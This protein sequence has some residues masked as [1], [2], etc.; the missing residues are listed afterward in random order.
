M[1]NINSVKI[2]DEIINTKKYNGINRELVEKIVSDLSAKYNEKQ[3]EKEVRNKLHQIWGTYFASMPDYNKLSKKVTD[4]QIDVEN[5]LRIH[6]SSGER[7]KFVKEMYAGIFEVTGQADSIIDFG[8]GFNPLSFQYM[9]IAK[10]GQYIVVDIDAKELEFLENAINQLKLVNDKKIDFKFVCQSALEFNYT[11]YEKVDIIFMLKLL[12]N[13]EQQDKGKGIEFFLNSFDHAKYVVVSFPTKS[14]SGNQRI[15]RVIILLGLKKF[16][17]R[18]R[19]R[20]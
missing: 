6:I 12:Q 19:F 17:R 10:N 1:A 9:N 4:S 2:V 18:I 7:L 5:L 20:C 14:V 16:L 11:N 13:L 8:S 15:W 3:L